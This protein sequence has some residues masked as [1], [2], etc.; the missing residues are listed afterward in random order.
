MTAPL[1]VKPS[2]FLSTCLPSCLLTIFRLLPA[3]T[4]HLLTKPA[5]YNRP[6]YL[7]WISGVLEF[8]LAQGV[9]LHQKV[10]EPGDHQNLTRSS[11]KTICHVSI[12]SP[13]NFSLICDSCFRYFANRQRW[14]HDLFPTL[15]VEPASSKRHNWGRFPLWFSYEIFYNYSRAIYF[16]CKF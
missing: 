15:L 1:G 10:P 12:S 8:T 11:M 13:P 14:A 16:S 2:W 5:F 6:V 3:P 9:T 4:D 7:I